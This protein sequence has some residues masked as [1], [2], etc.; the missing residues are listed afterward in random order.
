[1]KFKDKRPALFEKSTCNIWTD[2]YIQQQMLQAHLDQNSDGASRRSESI[3]KTVDLIKSAVPTGAHILDLGCGPGLYATILRD[4]DYQITGV[5]FNRA[6]IEYAVSCRKDIQYIEG[7]YIKEY[8]EGSFDAVM[9]IYCDMGTHSDEERD[10]LL[11]KIYHSLAD[12]GK[13]IFDLFTETLSDERAENQSWEYVPSGGF[14]SENDY[15]LLSQTF[16]YPE[17]RCFAY[18][19][20]LLTDN[21]TKHFILWD[22]YYN[23]AEVC[24]LLKRIGFRDVRIS[25]GLLGDNNFTS[26]SEMFIVAVK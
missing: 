15:L 18:Q 23:E 22:R 1:M 12:G 25:K 13:L 6:S 2:P 24:D 16:H 10:V 21:E 19:Y 9:M 3:A 5:D 4:A 20:N 14:W 26:G 11:R 17:N 7:D 8:P